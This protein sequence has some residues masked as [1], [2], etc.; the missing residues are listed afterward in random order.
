MDVR[1]E[2][3]SQLEALREYR[4]VEMAHRE[5]DDVLLELLERLGYEDVAEAF[6]EVPRWYA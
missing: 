2:A 3:L 4:D 1:M 6:R 5:A